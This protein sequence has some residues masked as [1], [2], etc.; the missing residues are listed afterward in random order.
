M[1]AGDE[2]ALFDPLSE[3]D[4]VTP[5]E[6]SIN[7]SWNYDHFFTHNKIGAKPNI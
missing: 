4:E 3:A 1:E 7:M 6:A 5:S 2:N